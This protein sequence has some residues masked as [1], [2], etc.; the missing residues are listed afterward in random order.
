MANLQLRNLPEPLHQKLRKIAAENRTTISDLVLAA[1]ERD[2]A[3]RE[4]QR[5]FNKREASQLGVRAAELLEEAR[6]DRED[7]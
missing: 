1:I 6:A 2:L 4:W 3:I 5:S 7:A